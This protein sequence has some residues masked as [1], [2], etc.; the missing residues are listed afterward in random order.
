MITIEVN[1]PITIGGVIVFAGLVWRLSSQYT[2]LKN[3]QTAMI[4]PL[5]LEKSVAELK[6]DLRK[7]FISKE[8][9]GG[10]FAGRFQE[11]ETRQEVMWSAFINT[12]LGT[13]LRGGLLEK[14]SP[15][16]W[17]FQAIERH[18]DFLDRLV[19]FY[20]TKKDLSDVELMLEIEKSFNI[21]LLKIAKEHDFQYAAILLAAVFY[22]RPDSQMFAKFQTDE[23]QTS[24]SGPVVTEA[25]E[26]LDKYNED[27][28]KEK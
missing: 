20:W 24:T 6:E 8:S 2:T 12:G 14:K 19:A 22:C 10:N 5:V 9:L 25:Q 26:R 4:T 18:K 7:E 1:T 16:R 17:S 3:V 13:G 27:S 28:S 23:W 15:L 11:L 21:D